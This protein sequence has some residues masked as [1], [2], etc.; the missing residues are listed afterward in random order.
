MKESKQ[1]RVIE[2]IQNRRQ[3][4]AVE[5]LEKTREIRKKITKDTG[6]WDGVKVLR[7]IRYAS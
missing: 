1:Q 4:R 5:I 7:D 2:S 3:I 6:D